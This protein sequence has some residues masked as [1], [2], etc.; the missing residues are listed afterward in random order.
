[1]LKRGGGGGWSRGGDMGGR[2]VKGWLSSEN[3]NLPFLERE[4]F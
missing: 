4:G 1:M 2:M 3:E